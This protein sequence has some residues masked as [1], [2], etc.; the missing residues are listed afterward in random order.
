LNSCKALCNIAIDFQKNLAKEEPLLKK[1]I[2]LTE[3]KNQEL[4]VAGIFTLK[5]LL[6]KCPKEVKTQVMKELTHGR[7]LALLDDENVN[8]V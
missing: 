3:S 4:R 6:F 2:E 7:L 8:V 1:L 5:N